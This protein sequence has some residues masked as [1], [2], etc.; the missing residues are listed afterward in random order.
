M[1]RHAKRLPCLT[2]PAPT[3]EGRPPPKKLRGKM[4]P[5]RRERWMADNRRFAP[6]TPMETAI[7]FVCRLARNEPPA[8][9]SSPPFSLSAAL[10][11][12]DLPTTCGTLRD[13]F[14][15]LAPA[16]QRPLLRP[17]VLEPGLTQTRAKWI[18]NFLGAPRMRH[19]IV[20]E[21]LDLV[22]PWKEHTEQFTSNNPTDRTQAPLF[23][24]LLEQTGFKL[25]GACD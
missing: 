4:E 23:L 3:P 10:P 13:H 6:W 8:L 5:E 9:G 11:H 21:V 17:P 20:S 19:E 18:A 22:S 25:Y 14:G 16:S 1:A 12:I 24:Y 7:Q 2:T 15:R